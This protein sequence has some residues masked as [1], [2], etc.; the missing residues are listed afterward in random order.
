MPLA[1]LD[2]ECLRLQ[3]QLPLMGSTDLTLAVDR[4]LTQLL[5][6]T[7]YTQEHLLHLGHKQ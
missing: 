4:C 6:V 3:C 7:S 5:D 1:G 2:I